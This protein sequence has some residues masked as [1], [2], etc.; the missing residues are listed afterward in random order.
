MV[1]HLAGPAE[2]FNVTPIPQLSSGSIKMNEPFFLCSDI[3]QSINAPHFHKKN[4]QLFGDL[5]ALTQVNNI[6]ILTHVKELA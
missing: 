3:S 2:L 5:Y 4:Y 1:C 6:K